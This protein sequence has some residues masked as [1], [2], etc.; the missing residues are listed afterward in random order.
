MEVMLKLILDAGHSQ[1]MPT[2]VGNLSK[3]SMRDA[4]VLQSI[5]GLVT[6]G[7][8]VVCHFFMQHPFQQH[9]VI[10][11][12]KVLNENLY[13]ESIYRSRDLGNMITLKFSWKLSRGK[14]YKEIEKK[15]QNEGYKQTGI[16]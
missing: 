5:L 13:K 11:R 4:M 16:M 9:P 15:V 2:M 1:D 6:G 7:V 10:Q 3:E 14:S 12:G 8:G